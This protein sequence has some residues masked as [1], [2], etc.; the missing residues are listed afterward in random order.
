MTL[1]DYQKPSSIETFSFPKLLNTNF[2]E[3]DFFD[4]EH[5]YN[6]ILRKKGLKFIIGNPP[7]KRGKSEKSTLFVKYIREREKQEKGSH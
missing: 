3:A 5:E 1:L 6:N 2:F 7:W 4:T